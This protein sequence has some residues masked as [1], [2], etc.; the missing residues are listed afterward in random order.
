MSRP[1]H[2]WRF[3]TGSAAILALGLLSG[4]G[5]SGPTGPKPV[6]TVTIAPTTVLVEAGQSQ[7]LTATA[8]DADGN[9]LTGR[10]ITWSTSDT[11]VATVDANGLLR[12]IIPG[13]ADV[14]ATAEQQTG[15]A[16]VTVSPVPVARVTISPRTA[17]VEI[18]STVSLTATA[19]SGTS[20]TLADR[21]VTWSSSDAATAT[22]SDSGVVTG[23]ARG[24]ATISALVE[25]ERDSI[26]VTV[27]VHSSGAIVV[28]T[29]APD[30]LVEG[31]SA[32]LAG[33]G[34]SSTATGNTVFV[35]NL[36]AT[37][38]A[39]SSTSLTFTVPGFDCRPAR[40]VDLQ[41]V[42]S[43]DGS[44][45][46]QH[47]LRPAAAPLKVA[48]GQQ[49]ILRD[50]SAFCLQFAASTGQE[51]Y[52]LGVQSVS[53]A[54]TSLTPATVSAETATNLVAS[55]V[56][57]PAPALPA[58][59][60]SG[61]NAGSML[62]ST[63]ASRWDRQR[64]AEA[65]IINQSLRDIR[66]YRHDA[67]VRALMRGPVRAA[68]AVPPGTSVGDTV[69]IHVPVFV[70]G[71]SACDTFVTIRTIV[72]AIGKAGIWVEDVAN[73]ANGFTTSDIQTLSSVFDNTIYDVDTAYFGAPSDNDNNGHV[74]IVITKEVN[75][76]KDVL[77]FVTSTDF[78]PP[79][80]CASSNDG[81]FYYGRA[82]DPTGLYEEPAPYPL[83]TAK[84][85]AQRL[86]AHEFTHD[87]QFAHRFSN[88]NATDFQP[89]WLL[90]GQATLAEEV[91]GNAFEGR[92]T[93]Q[94][95]G[96]DVAFN[97]TTPP[98]P[99]DWYQDRFEDLAVYF[100]F[101]SRTSKVPGA[102]EQCSWLG[103]ADEGNDGPCLSGREV[104]GVPWS[105]LRWLSDQFGPSF[106]GGE[107]GLQRALV[108]DPNTG[109]ATI[110]NV[111]GMPMDSLLAQWSAMLYVDDRGVPGLPS[112]LMLPSWNMAD[113][114]S[115]V[116]SPG[117]L[118]PRT[119]TFTNFSDQIEVRGGST[120]YYIVSGVGRNATAIKVR[121][122]G[123]NPL[124][125]NMRLWVVRLQ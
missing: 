44:N 24:T 6:A 99:I 125:S 102:P 33:V 50:P 77:G 92:S 10:T 22:V 83:D 124:P 49:L 37:V 105:I 79:A 38:T 27:T 54:V 42:V 91:V 59:L 20:D 8:H 26:P 97:Q 65:R 111:I 43:G 36:P 78:V 51:S 47:P 121:D 16:S 119:L 81:E 53:D 1:S 67:T 13:T 2:W 113:I 100:G 46:V 15:R 17:S 94:N 114:F 56:H 3:G 104:Y 73:P 66:P 21:A 64:S 9:V 74:V 28:A 23:V 35:D 57:P 58:F 76:E 106:P 72:R 71:Q 12:G 88:P 110:E 115:H 84:L 95:L 19:L 118:T 7:Q 80:Q 18:G 108:D 82:P 116:V 63:R 30:S 34:F 120:G 29:V 31:Q 39:A 68:A 86:I 89:T 25:G 14:T 107:Q 101:Q 32:T 123:D 75:K 48:V 5:D 55:V 93:G 109:F 117:Q 103:T 90:E 4:C 70:T 122:L 85:D 62:P 11:A 69:S 40:D 45:I 41:V 96:A 52:L 87:I 112:R 60:R 61:T 98:S